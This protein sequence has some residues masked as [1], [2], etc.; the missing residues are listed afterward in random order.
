MIARSGIS[1]RTASPAQAVATQS[2][3]SS[4]VFHTMRADTGTGAHTVIGAAGVLIALRVMAREPHSLGMVGLSSYGSTLQ[5]DRSGSQRY[6]EVGPRVATMCA[7]WGVYGALLVRL[8]SRG[9]EAHVSVDSE[10][11]DFVA[12][13]SS[14]LRRTAYLLTGDQGHADDLVQ[15]ALTKVYLSW[16][17]IRNGYAAEAYARRTLVTTYTS[18]WRRRSWQERP[19]ETLGERDQPDH[20]DALVDRADL[21]HQLR[22]LPRQQ[23]AVIVLRFYEDLTTAATADALGI[24]V[25][26]VKSYTSRALAT[27][28]IQLTDRP[29]ADAIRSTR[30]DHA[31]HE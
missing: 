14:S 31:E 16:E 18:W 22:S 17:R 25:G 15:T 13:R 28:R 3:I 21:R 26:T 5:D 2:T 8:G 27:L 12:A 23:R 9:Q 10:F 1:T 24:S 19:T 7:C 30:S 4:P 6:P 29:T 11:R 20:T